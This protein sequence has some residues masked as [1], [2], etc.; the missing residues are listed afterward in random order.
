MRL[1]SSSQPGQVPCKDFMRSQ[2]SAAGGGGGGGG[3]SA[4]FSACPSVRAACRRKPGHIAPSLASTAG[5]PMEKETAGRGPAIHQGRSGTRI[6]TQSG[7]I[8]NL[9]RAG[10]LGSE[11]G[12]HNRFGYARPQKREK[13]AQPPPV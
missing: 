11:F 10:S 13:L 2:R 8:E 7:I 5:E 6:G 4:A 9:E 1:P 3:A 12:R